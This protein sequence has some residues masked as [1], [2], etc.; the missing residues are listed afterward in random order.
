MKTMHYKRCRSRKGLTVCPE[1]L[2]LIFRDGANLPRRESSGLHRSH[3]GNS[4]GF[5]PLA[6]RPITH[7]AS[8]LHLAVCQRLTPSFGLSLGASQQQRSTTI[9]TNAHPALEFPADG[10]TVTDFHRSIV[11]YLDWRAERGRTY[12]RSRHT[13]EFHEYGA[14]KHLV[15]SA[16]NAKSPR[17]MMLVDS[18][19]FGDLP[20]SPS[21]WPERLRL[22][23][24]AEQRAA[25]ARVAEATRQALDVDK[26][27]KSAKAES[28]A[29]RTRKTA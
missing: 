29:E 4:G 28:L 15:I 13:P 1:P 18:I 25:D 2:R 17:P 19:N 20:A 11:S 24:E 10:R 5:G 23:H 9:S 16:F 8:L 21:E 26:K 6:V 7:K 12:I 27:K 14:A 3:L 22:K